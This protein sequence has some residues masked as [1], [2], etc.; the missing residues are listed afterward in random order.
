M[1][2]FFHISTRYSTALDRLTTKLSK[3][4]ILSEFHGLSAA[5][6]CSAPARQSMSFLF[7]LILFTILASI[8]SCFKPDPLSFIFFVFNLC[9]KEL[10]SSLGL[11]FDNSVVMH[12]VWRRN[13]YQ[14][15]FCFIFFFIWGRICIF[16]FVGYL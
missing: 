13:M 15:F 2:K 9:L 12:Y 4:W 7:I 8:W 3:M 1:R 16:N 14:L 5:L 11:L 6:C 10:L